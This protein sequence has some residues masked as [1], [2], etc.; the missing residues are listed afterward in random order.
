MKKLLFSILIISIMMTGLDTSRAKKAVDM[1]I[2]SDRIELRHDIFTSEELQWIE[3]HK[4]IKFYV[5]VAQDYIPIEYIDENNNPRGMGIELLKKA[6]QMTGLHFSL[7]ENSSNETWEEILQSTEK[8][9]VDLLSTVSFTKGRSEYLTFSIPYIEMT[10]VILGAKDMTQLVKDFSQIK[11]N[12]FAVPKGYWFL[13][14]I[15]NEIPGAKIIDVTNMEEA[16]E[17]V[18]DG[19]AD[20]TI[21]EIP[22]FT[23]YTEQGLFHDIKIVGELKGKNRIYIGAAKGR[24]ELITIINKVIQN[25]DYDEIFEKAMV[26]PRNNSATKKLI[27][28]V[29]ILTVLLLVVIYYLC[30]T[31]RKLIKSKKE[32]EEANRDK[33]QLMANISHDLRTPMTVII[34]YAQAL[35]DGEVKKEED[36][37]KYIKRVY[38]KIKHVSAMVDDF[39]MVARLEEGNLVLNREPVQI[40]A[41]IKQI[42]EDSELKFKAKAIVPV[43]RMD[44]RA[45]IIKNI[46]K[47]KFCRAIENI[48]ENAIKYSAEGGKI[49]IILCP[50]EDEKVEISIRDYGEGIPREDIPH[51]FDRY[52]KGKN[53]RKDSIGLGLYI[54]KEIINKHDG[55]LWATS[56]VQ[57]GSIFYIRI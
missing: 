4:D 12:T 18:S 31:F 23:Y 13:D 35:I 44:N 20:F 49:E 30:I 47:I 46:D 6:N 2:K 32:A 11:D 55:R 33:T 54:A 21:C 57:R 34:G 52:Y 36:K 14:I 7:Y 17:Y 38:E 56:E 27:I 43:L 40:G 45:D 37:E 25:M 8:A 29:G 24:E 50:A 39:F 5:G 15:L 9:R 48:L 22:V 28:L 3:A 51:I 26:I 41:F 53:A 1:D 10:Q 42:V 16:L 19:K